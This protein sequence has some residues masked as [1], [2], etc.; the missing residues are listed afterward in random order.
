[1]I[2]DERRK[3]Y[4]QINYSFRK[5]R[6]Q[7]SSFCQPTQNTQSHA[8][9]IQ[10]SAN[11]ND[12]LVW[13]VRCLFHRRRFADEAQATRLHATTTTTTPHVKHT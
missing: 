3:T 12:H 9:I 11:V 5:R 6:V 10:R 8:I 2:V 7:T 1:M 4:K 13:R